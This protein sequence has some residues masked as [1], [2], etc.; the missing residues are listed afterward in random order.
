MGHAEPVDVFGEAK[1]VVGGSFHGVVVT[2]G[3]VFELA[4]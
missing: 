3:I 2:G 1:V 4:K